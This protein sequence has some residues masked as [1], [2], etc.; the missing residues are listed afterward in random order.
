MCVCITESYGYGSP[1]QLYVLSY[2]AV[3]SVP[4]SCTFCLAVVSSVLQLYIYS[5]CTPSF[6]HTFVIVSVYPNEEFVLSLSAG[7]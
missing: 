6:V 7:A 4:H 5:R 1:A 3:C 2:T